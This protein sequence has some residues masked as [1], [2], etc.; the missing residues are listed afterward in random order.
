MRETEIEVRSQIV[1]KW[2]VGLNKEELY[3]G[4]KP[5]EE[6][7]AENIKENSEE[8]LLQHQEE[9]HQK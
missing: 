5:L 6:S 3:N 7:R 1:D 4:V 2:T 9:H 8:E